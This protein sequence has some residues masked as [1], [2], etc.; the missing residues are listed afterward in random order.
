MAT[1]T[2]KRPTGRRAGDSGTRDAILDA[3][4][5]LFGERG[6]DGTS[7]RA[8]AAQAGVDPALIRHFFGDKPTLFATVVAD[9]TGIPELVQ[10]ALTG[11]PERVGENVTRAFLTL[12]EEP[13]SRPILLALLRSAVTSPQ[14]AQLLREILPGRSPAF[15]EVV[16]RRSF[17]L[18]ASHLFGIAL[19]RHVIGLPT[20]TEPTLDELV[21]EAAPTI[22]RYLTNTHR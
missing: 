20:M 10:A 12:W 4:L 21:A 19:A 18:A 9:G 16:S 14:A 8:I 7:V 13:Q 11:D 15:R 5:H 17:G 3:A 22:H 6:Y 2:R 1:T